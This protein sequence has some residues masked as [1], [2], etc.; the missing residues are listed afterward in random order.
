MYR[1]FN[2]IHRLLLW[3]QILI[4]NYFI[5]IYCLF[6]NNNSFTTFVLIIHLIT[7]SS[8]LF[9]VNIYTTPSKLRYILLNFFHNCLRIISIVLIFAFDKFLI[10]PSI[11]LLL[12]VQIS[13]ILFD[14][15]CP[16]MMFYTTDTQIT[17]SGKFTLPLGIAIQLIK[18][19]YLL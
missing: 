11:I 1:N 6:M 10:I 9:I 15:N 3:Q 5:V 7:F 4:L 17:G 18:L 13:W 2:S 14:Y 19:L 16:M 8:Y 12:T